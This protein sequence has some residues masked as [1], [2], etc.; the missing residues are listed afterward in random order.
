MIWSP[1][2]KR[3][4]CIPWSFTSIT[5]TTDVCMTSLCALWYVIGQ[6]AVSDSCTKITTLSK[7]LIL[8]E[9]TRLLNDFISSFNHSFDISDQLSRLFIQVF[10]WN[11][12]IM[13]GSSLDT[14]TGQTITHK[15][16]PW[17]TSHATNHV[18]FQSPHPI[19]NYPNTRKVFMNH[20]SSFEQLG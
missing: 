9:Y 15:V 12:A 7:I 11:T 20:I 18:F 19:W 3:Q 8:S 5:L 4:R 2:W 13:R 17:S 16:S 6:S 1:L 14:P 10:G